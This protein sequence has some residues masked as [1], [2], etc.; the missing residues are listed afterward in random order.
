MTIPAL[1]PASPLTPAYARVGQALPPYMIQEGAPG[2]AADW[3]SGAG[4]ARG[5]EDLADF[6]AHDARQVVRTY[7]QEARPQVAATFALH[8][9]AWPAGLLFT[10]P[11]FLLRRVPHLTPGDV[12]LHRE[13]PRVAV[14]AT[15]FS[16][17]PDDPASG[18]PAARVVRDEETLRA[19]VRSAAAAHL[20]PVME[21]FGPRMRRRGR[22]L[23][24]MAADELTDGLW[25]L[26]RLLGEEER[27]RQEAELLLP[28]GT[29]PYAGGAS[30]RDLTGPDGERLVTRDRV[31]CCLFYTLRPQDTCVTCPR[32]CDTERIERLSAERR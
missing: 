17:L 25:L 28:G 3:V 27:A 10:L 21:A 24:G 2:D 12:F 14:R 32:T 22:A 7:G 23:W 11:W 20:G 30:F 31:S 6:V 18:H 19:T 29:A 26:G 1:A 15:E 5:G 16:C 8:R 13:E 4:L 9:Y